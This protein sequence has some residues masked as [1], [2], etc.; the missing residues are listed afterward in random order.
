M[1]WDRVWTCP[2]SK[3]PWVA[4]V[5]MVVG[6]LV[7]SAQNPELQ[8]K[9]AEVKEAMAANKQALAQYTWQEQVTV[10]LK[11]D[12]KKQEHFQV[13]LG[14]DGKAQKQSLD[15]P[16]APAAPSGGRIKQRVI[17]KKKDEYKDY[18]DQIKALIQQ[19]VPPEKAMLE[20]AAQQG[21]VTLGPAGG[22]PGQYQLVLSNYVKP[23][24]K[25]TLLFDKERKAL[26]SVTIASYLSDPKDAVNVSVTFAG[27]P[28][29]PNHIASESIDGVSKQLTIVIANSLYQHL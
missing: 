13:R 22:A 9:V 1:K 8:Q 5:V 29:G 12:V 21:N 20:Q 26:V 28:G 23:G 16:Q 3:R 19:Y 17:E 14:P 7:V 15:A 18:V 4:A 27:I 2:K 6:A 25:M 10:S 24:D 11:G